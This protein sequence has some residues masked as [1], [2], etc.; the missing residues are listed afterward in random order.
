M[1]LWPLSQE[2]D[3]M[4]ASITVACWCPQTLRMLSCCIW[5]GAFPVSNRYSIGLGHVHKRFSK[6]VSVDRKSIFSDS[7]VP[8]PW[9]SVTACRFSIQTFSTFL[10]SPDHSETSF[11]TLS[12][13]PN[14]FRNPFVDWARLIFGRFFMP[15]ANSCVLI[16][17]QIPCVQ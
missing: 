17:K 7:T 4:L 10:P 3:V 14:R 9:K 16:V 13:C 12:S 11:G 8:A 6:T 15:R 5:R 1:L 2:A